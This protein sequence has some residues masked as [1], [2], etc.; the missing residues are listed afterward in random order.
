MSTASQL[1]EQ[2]A[3]L[4]REYY[5]AQFA[6]RPSSPGHDLVHYAGRVFDEQELLS[7]VDSSLDFF[8]TANRYSDRFGSE[9]ADY[10]GVSDALLV[11]SGSSANLVAVTALTSPK[12]GDRRLK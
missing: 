6:A 5:Q 4:V 7:L 10:M 9:L 1:R 8:L 2:I 12:L 11:N 3:A